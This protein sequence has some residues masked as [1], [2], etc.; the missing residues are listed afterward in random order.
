[1]MPAEAVIASPVLELKDL[2][3]S[4]GAASIING[5][6]LTIAAGERHAVIGPN[7]AGKSTLFNLMSGLFAPSSGAILLAGQNI[8]GLPAHLI[9]RRGLAR[10]FQI[11]NIFVRLSVLENVRIAC[12]RPAGYLYSLFRAVHRLKT[13]NE[14]A[15]H[16]VER[17]GLGAVR[18]KIAGE[19]TYSEQRAL[20]I[21]MTVAGKPSVVLLDEPTAGMSR[22]ETAGAID[23]IRS[24]SAG[25]TLLIVE[26]D[27]EVVFSLCDRI[28]VLVY[29]EIISSGSPDQIRAD[30]R[31]QEAYLGKDRA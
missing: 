4:F 25:K 22:N 26:H 1:M 29:G 24:M 31:V 19:L 27:M 18:D 15:E 13:V 6:N 3:K 8:A 30:P 17:V 21:A 7:G 12:L 20:E 28:S 2:R 5:V 9:Q 14:E 23:L 10:S 11:T 16:L